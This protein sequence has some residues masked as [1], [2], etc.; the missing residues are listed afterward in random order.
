MCEI[1]VNQSER[2]KVIK[3]EKSSMKK[4]KKVEVKVEVEDQY[5]DECVLRAYINNAK[6]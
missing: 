6:S 2:E 4:K 1:L 5:H 3:V